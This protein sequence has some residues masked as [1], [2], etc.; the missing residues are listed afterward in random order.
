[1]RQAF[2]LCDWAELELEVPYLAWSKGDIAARGVSLGVPYELTWTCY[3]GGDRPCGKCG[4][5][6]ERAEAFA[7]AGVPDPFLEAIA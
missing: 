6:V 1:M 2:T 3:E 7:F 4:A 5:C